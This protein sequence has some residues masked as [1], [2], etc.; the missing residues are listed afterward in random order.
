MPIKPK[1]RSVAIALA[2]I[3]YTGWLGIDR[4]YLA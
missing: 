1:S 2:S 3:P 4:F